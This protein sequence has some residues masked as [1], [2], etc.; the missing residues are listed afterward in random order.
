M[1]LTLT[2]LTKPGVN[3]SEASDVTHAVPS[4][5]PKLQD[6]EV[7]KSQSSQSQEQSKAGKITLVTPDCPRTAASINCTVDTYGE[8]I[9]RLV[10]YAVEGHKSVD[11]LLCAE[12]GLLSAAF[13]QDYHL[14]AHE[15]IDR[16]NGL[17]VGMTKEVA[18][19]LIEGNGTI[20]IDLKTPQ[21]DA[22]SY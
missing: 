6:Q 19:A 18:I 3:A 20:S 12:F 2:I 15:L 11:D 7:T 10:E 17:G 16:A 9:I 13:A 5:G 21:C 1:E 22:V 14:I 8:R 4:V